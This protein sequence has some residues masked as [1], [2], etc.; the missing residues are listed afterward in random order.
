MIGPCGGRAS[1]RR[2][3]VENEHV[4]AGAGVG[5]GEAVH[6]EDGADERRRQGFRR[7]PQRDE[8]ALVQ[9]CDAVGEWGHKR[10][11]V[12]HPDDRDAETARQGE[13]V[14]PR[15]RIE[16]VGRLVENEEGRLLRDGPGYRAPLAFA[17]GE[18]VEPSG[19]EMRDPDA[20]ER[21]A[22]E[23]GVLS[24]QNPTLM[25]DAAE[26]DVICQSQAEI[27]LIALRHDRDAQRPPVERHVLDWLAVDHDPPTRRSQKPVDQLQQGRLTC[28]GIRSR[29][30]RLSGGPQNAQSRAK[31]ASINF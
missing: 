1:R 17:P 22:H 21:R 16:M 26:I 20:V 4:P 29:R 28:L 27:G 30:N 5:R 19:G 8:A 15:T 18:V 10:E 7:R 6:V 3:R 25:R 14:G 13:H 2:R 31:E 11:V 24:C 9:H 23:T 12:Q